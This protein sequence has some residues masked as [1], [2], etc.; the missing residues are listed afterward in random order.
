MNPTTNPALRSFVDVP[1]DSHFPIQNLPY[2]VFSEDGG[3]D[4]T[5]H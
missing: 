5:V 1:A 3:P 2:G 4:E